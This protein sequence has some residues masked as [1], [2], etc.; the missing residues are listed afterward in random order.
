ML[1]MRRSSLI[2]LARSAITPV[3]MFFILMMIPPISTLF[4]YTTLFRSLHAVGIVG[5]VL[6]RVIVGEERVDHDGRGDRHQRDR[7]S[8]RLKSSHAK[9]SYAVF[10]LKKKTKMYVVTISGAHPSCRGQ[11]SFC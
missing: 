9:I 10:C 8:T 3:N 5:D 4:P 11:K 6:D 7:K 2:I 1:C